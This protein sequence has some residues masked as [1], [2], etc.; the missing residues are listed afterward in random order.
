[1]IRFEGLTTKQVELLDKLWSLDTSEE[2]LEWF[3]TLDDD[4][5]RT[6]VTLQE[7]VIDALLE[8][9]AESD[10]KLAKDMLQSIGV[11]C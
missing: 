11:K 5:F 1:M 7:M 8:Q 3:S 6:A 9:P 10:T 2:L 4:D